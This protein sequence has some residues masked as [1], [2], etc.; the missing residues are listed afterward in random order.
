MLNAFVYRMVCREA[1]DC[2]EYSLCAATGPGFE[3]C[4]DEGGN[5]YAD[6]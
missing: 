6:E 2:F 1:V 5:K 3:G 4:K